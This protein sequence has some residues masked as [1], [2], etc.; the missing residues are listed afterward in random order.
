MDE[1]GVLVQGRTAKELVKNPALTPMNQQR[2]AMVVLARTVPL[3]TGK[4]DRT[5][6]DRE[7]DDILRERV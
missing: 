1:N 7:I 4:V 6:L 5:E 3:T 2:A